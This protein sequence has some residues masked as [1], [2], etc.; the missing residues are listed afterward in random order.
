[1]EDLNKP[2]GVLASPSN[3]ISGLFDIFVI[4]VYFF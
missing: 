1:M 3:F 2:T 4:F